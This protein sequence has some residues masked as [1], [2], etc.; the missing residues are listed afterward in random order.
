MGRIILDLDDDDIEYAGE[1]WA[2]AVI[3]GVIFFVTWE[4]LKVSALFLAVAVFL[5]LCGFQPL[6]TLYGH[7]GPPFM[8]SVPAWTE[9]LATVLLLSLGALALRSYIRRRIGW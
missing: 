8:N 3:F 7:I 2:G 4:L 9:V 1:E 6:F 5:V